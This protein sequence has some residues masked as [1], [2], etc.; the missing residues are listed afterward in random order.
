V[1]P[2]CSSA[3][4][5]IEGKEGIKSNHSIPSL[6]RCRI[7]KKAR[8]VGPFV[9]L[10]QHDYSWEVGQ[11]DYAWKMPY[12]VWKESSFYINDD[13]RPIGEISF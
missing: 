9:S 4:L 5:K 1:A 7:L 13:P 11:H 8:G 6:G 3:V 10:G 2:H 12:L